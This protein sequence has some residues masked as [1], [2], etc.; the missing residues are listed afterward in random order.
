MSI[1]G[2][3]AI[4][5]LSG[6]L[7]ST[8][9]LAIAKSE[10]FRI[11]ALTFQYGQRHEIEVEAA[12]RVAHAFNVER[13]IVVPIDLRIFAGSALTADIAVPKNRSLDEI[14]QGIPVTYVPA[15]NTIFLAYALAFAEVVGAEDIFF[16]ANI[17]DYSVGGDAL[18][19]VRTSQAA[20]LMSIQDFY[21]MPQGDYHTVAVDPI[22]L[23]V[24][25]RRVTGRF[26]HQSTHKRCFRVRL[27]RGQEIT[28]T[29]DHSLFTIDPITA[30]IVTIKG[31][32]MSKGMPIVVPFD[33]SE[34]A[35]AWS[36][37]L[38]FLDLSGLMRSWDGRYTR[39]SV[40][41]IGEA[42]TNRL[43]RTRV[44][45]RFPVTDDFLYIVGLWLAE[46]GKALHSSTGTLS[47]SIGGIPGAVDTLRS[48]FEQFNVSVYKSPE[49]TYDYV[50]HSSV[51]AA[52]FKHFG[53]FGTAKRG[54]KAFPHFF[55]DLSQRQ[56]RV[57][58]AGLW[59][60]DGSHVFK[61]ECSLA[62]KSHRLIEELYHCFSLDGIF[63]TIKDA[64]H[65]QKQLFLRRA[66]DFRRFVRLYPLRHPS[67]RSAYETRTVIKG[68]DQA[69]GV[70]KCPGLWDAVA[71]ASLQPGEKTKIY[72]TGGKYDVSFRSQRAA[73]ARVPSL[74]HLAASRLAFLRVLDVSEVCLPR[75][76][77]LSVEGAENFVAN[78]ILA[79]NSGYPDCRPEYI[80]AFE[81][82]AHLATKAAVEGQQRIRIHTPL[83]QLSKAQI[84]QRGLELGVDYGLTHS[85]YDPGADGRPCGEC[86]ACL[87]RLK[88]F[89]ELGLADPVGTRLSPRPAPGGG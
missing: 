36:S 45:M 72:N 10:G 53:L 80:Q 16:G 70:W 12:R 23:Q 84:I 48:F 8:T 9:T 43:G 34:V 21:E 3:P 68:R 82:L 31:S 27:E 58:I 59:D 41:V 60:G 88:G 22:T 39:G 40:V 29:E 19:W 44:P 5:L 78:G 54:E 11:H 35:D 56:R 38:D 79:H 67:K 33:L 64:P 52:I 55:W 46:G 26:R 42:L 63:P 71:A 87:L 4:V 15:R 81:R 30:G 25:W 77:D 89:G 17:Y 51:F 18:I 1:E 47:F 62:Q 24:Q 86:D 7:D 49:N 65:S 20:R 57:L 6:G 14:G 85:C 2:T 32:E 61:K 13:H 50:V 76:Y 73:F 37:E 83:I 74:Q 66:Q 69:T 28:I 75:M